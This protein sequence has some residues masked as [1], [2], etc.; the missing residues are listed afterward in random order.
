[1]NLKF[2]FYPLVL[3]L[4]A[5]PFKYSQK[6]FEENTSDNSDLAKLVKQEF[7]HSW[8]AYKQYAWGNDDL[9]PLSKSYHNWHDASLLMTPVDALDVMYIMGLNEE[10]DSTKEYIIKNL[11]FDCDFFVKNFEI[12][13]RILGGLI[14]AYQLTNDNR[15]LNL[16]DDLGK[17]LLPVF[18]SPTGMPYMFV[19]LK[20][21]EVRGEVSNPAEIGTLLIEFGTLSKLTLN[22]VYYDKAKKAL[23]ELYNRRSSIGLVGTTINVETGEWGNSTSHI[24]GMIDSYYEYLLKCWLLFDDEDCKEMWET[25][26]AAINKY[27]AHETETGLWYAQV[28]MYTGERIATR[29]GALDAFFPAVLALSG[30]TER[31]LRLQESCYKM[32]NLHGI[33]PE[34][35]DYINNEIIYSGYPLRPE[36]I[37]SAYYLY[38]FTKDERYLE[39]GKAFLEILIK[40]CKTD[41]GYT[42]LQNVVTKEKKDEMESFFLAETLKY[43]YLLFAPSETLDFSKVIFNTEAHPV[44][45]TW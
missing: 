7:L 14:S 12:T 22:P 29:F 10:A 28:N 30:D 18:N 15:L 36:I 20:T 6:Y 44:W 27:V 40:Y 45:R 26:I 2:I 23:V 17:R 4:L 21:G 35:F 19:N 43:F 1:M 32:W 37:E 31:A 25:S 16:A 8:N 33:E 34:R 3:I 9:K 41:A 39:M 38:H 13:I 11:S 24:S 42:A 5:S